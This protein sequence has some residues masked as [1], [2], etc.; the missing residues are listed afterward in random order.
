MSVYVYHNI[1]ES[2]MAMRTILGGLACVD[3]S[4]GTSDCCLDWSGGFVDIDTPAEWHCTLVLFGIRFV[5]QEVAV[6][7]S[8]PVWFVNGSRMGWALGTPGG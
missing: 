3:F 8:G 2:R 6:M 5:F 7:N 4:V 1:A